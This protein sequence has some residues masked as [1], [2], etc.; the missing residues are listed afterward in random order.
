M[1]KAVTL[2][3]LLV[4]ALA[5]AGLMWAQD[6]QITQGPKVETVNDN[7]AVIAWSTNASASTVVKYGT[8]QN[9]LDQTAEAPWGG[10]T[11]RV[12]IK[13]LIPG[14]TYF[15]TVQSGQ[16]QGTGSATNSG[17]QSFTT[18][19]GNGQAAQQ[20]AQP[21]SDNSQNQQWQYNLQASCSNIKAN[22][23]DVTWNTSRRGSSKVLYNTDPNNLS[24]TVMAPWGE[25]NHKVTISNLQP[26]TKYYYQVQTEGQEGNGAKEASPLLNCTTNKQ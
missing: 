2:S 6:V 13:N 16:A 11:H 24:Q 21:Q 17:T 3:T 18:T 5:L 20:A 22:S 23:F 12:T 10:L 19:G 1:R 7:S 8:D 14:T 15:F 4:A 26:G 25:T 9:K